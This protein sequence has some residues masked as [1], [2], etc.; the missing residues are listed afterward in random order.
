MLP[1]S[2]METAGLLVKQV[3]PCPH[4]LGQPLL[5]LAKPRGSCLENVAPATGVG[6]AAASLRLSFASE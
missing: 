4:S 6:T 2:K 5:L 1:L 3:S